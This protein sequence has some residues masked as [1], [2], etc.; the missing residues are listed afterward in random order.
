M[1]DFVI[2]E[3]AD[4]AIPFAASSAPL[5]PLIADVPMP[6]NDVAIDPNPL[7][8]FVPIPAAKLPPAI[9]LLTAPCKPLAIPAAA[10]VTLLKAPVNAPAAA[11]V[12]LLKAPVN[13]P[14]AAP[15]TLL[16]A[17]VNAPAAAPAEFC[18]KSFT[19]P[20]PT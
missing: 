20:I 7:V 15:V 1:N 17:P 6:P 5:I 10:P 2:A 4:P 3:N 8:K 11:P 19:A 9:A 13:A 14:A 18:T 16:K 12:T